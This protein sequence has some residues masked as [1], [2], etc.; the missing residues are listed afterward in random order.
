M[1]QNFQ[2]CLII[3]NRVDVDFD[4]KLGSASIELFG[5]GT[6]DT[7]MNISVET[8][9]QIEKL[10]AMLK[11]SFPEDKNDTECRKEY[12]RTSIDMA[13]VFSGYQG[14]V[15]LRAFMENFYNSIDFE[16]KFPLK[17]VGFEMYQR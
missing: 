10:T 4:K 12:F 2:E 13:K 3:C 1:S 6:H 7:R 15:F 14:T 9:F 8:F 5:D 16:P 17:K 11:I